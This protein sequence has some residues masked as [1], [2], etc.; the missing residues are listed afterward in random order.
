MEIKSVIHESH[1][2]AI[3]KGWWDPPCRQIPELLA[4]VHSEVSE[5]LESYREIGPE[6]LNKMWYEETKG[7]PEGF[8]V[9]LADIIIRIADMCGE[10]DLDLDKALAEKMAYNKTRSY[11]HGNKVV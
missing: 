3:K 1:S 6:Q 10:F 4:L 7:K 8:T 5:A 9:E 2:T 11:R